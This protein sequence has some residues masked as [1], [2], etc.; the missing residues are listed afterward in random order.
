MYV[1]RSEVDE[2]PTM[3]HQTLKRLSISRK[4]SVSRERGMLEAVRIELYSTVL[5]ISRKG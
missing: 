5:Q 4:D 1:T 2:L 3:A